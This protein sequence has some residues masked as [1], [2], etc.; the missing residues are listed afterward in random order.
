MNHS[1]HRMKEVVGHDSTKEGMPL[2]PDGTKLG[3]LNLMIT[4]N[5]NSIRDQVT[6]IQLNQSRI[7]ELELF[8]GLKIGRNLSPASL[9]ESVKQWTEQQ[10]VKLDDWERLQRKLEN[11]IRD[12]ERDL[13]E[14]S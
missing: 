5:E 7:L 9:E 11:Y 3:R 4:K 14:R 6:K 1:L 13:E 2:R 8:L 10:R 12:L